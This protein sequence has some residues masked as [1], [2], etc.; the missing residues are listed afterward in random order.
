MKM[1]ADEEP[2][3]SSP[4]RSREEAVERT[5]DPVCGKGAEDAKQEAGEDR[6]QIDERKTRFGRQVPGKPE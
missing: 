3:D 4:G 5:A 6:D 1:V 2:P